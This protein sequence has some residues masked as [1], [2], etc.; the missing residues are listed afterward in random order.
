MVFLYSKTYKTLKNPTIT[1]S[2]AKFQELVDKDTDSDGV[3]DWEEVLWGT[4]PSKSATFGMSDKDYI[5]NK[6]KEISAKNETGDNTS[7]SNPNDT[8]KLAQEFLAAVIALKE[9]GNL[10]SFNI[11]NLAQK[12]SQDIGTDATLKTSYTAN[13]IQKASTDTAA[14]KKAYYDKLTKA[15]AAAKKSG[16]GGEVNE[17]ANYF[18]NES[19]NPKALIQLTGT[20]ATLTKSLKSMQVPTSAATMHLDLLNESDNMASIFKNISEI[21]DNSIIG[22]VAIAQFELN[23]PKM[24]KTL[25]D[26]I[27][28]FKTN[29]IIK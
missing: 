21:N 12:F 14:V 9:S 16:M 29:A 18:S 7:V 2:T 5:A 22:L 20:Y 17:V 8:E 25:S 24:E 19:A 4:D 3:K 28:Y 26:L 23:E 15:I 11:N 27:A 10:N 6:R 1:T 13:D